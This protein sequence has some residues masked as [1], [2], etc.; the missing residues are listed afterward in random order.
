[1]ATGCLSIWFIAA[2]N[3]L[4]QLATAPGMRGRVMG[5][6]GTA[7]PGSNVL[8]ARPADVAAAQPETA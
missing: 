3:T 5:L 8:T 1:M 2:A 6:W 4:V 7:L